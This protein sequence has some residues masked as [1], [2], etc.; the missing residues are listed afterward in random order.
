MRLVAMY[1]YSLCHAYDTMSRGTLISFAIAPC[2]FG[3]SRFAI[4]A[5]ALE[6]L[7]APANVLSSLVV[8]GYKKMMLVS[9]II[10]GN[11]PALPKYAS[12]AVTRHLKTHTSE[13]EALASCCQVW[14][15]CVWPNMKLSVA[16]CSEV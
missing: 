6:L 1:W 11:I 5:F 7:T 8:E 9:L 2:R 10:S 13:Y 4:F 3:Y 14:I 16:M 12:N 15:R